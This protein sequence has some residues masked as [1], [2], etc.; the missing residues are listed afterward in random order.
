MFGAIGKIFKNLPALAASTA[1][2]I[3]AWSRFGVDHDLELGPAL[4]GDRYDIADGSGGQVAVYRRRSTAGAPVLLV[5]S[6][7]AAASAY[8]MKPLFE[9]FASRRPVFALDL[10]GY[11][12]STRGDR[13][14]TPQ[15]MADAI[16]NLLES[17][18]EPAHVVALSLS[19]EFSAR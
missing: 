9:Q 3:I 12:H 17:I 11:G 10:P 7:N 16:S 6:V 13:S 4:N 15:L 5:H 19:S 1:G 14:Y 18:G 2:S 8:E